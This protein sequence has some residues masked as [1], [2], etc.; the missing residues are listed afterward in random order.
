ML[1]RTNRLGQISGKASAAAVLAFALA[2]TTGSQPLAAEKAAVPGYVKQATWTQTMLATR[3][4]CRK[5]LADDAQNSKSSAFKPFISDAIRGEGPGQKVSVNVAG[6]DKLRLVTVLEQMPGNC[7]I[8]GEARLIAKDGTET[9]LSKLKPL[10]VRVGWGQLLADKNWQDHSLQIGE[11]QFK[12]GLWVH[13]DSDLCYSLGGKYERFEAWVG[14]DKDRAGGAARF[15]VLAAASD[16]VPSAW[17]QLAKDFP[18]ESKW[19]L[20]DSGRGKHLDWFYNSGNVRT[21]QGLIQRVAG[22][23]GS[24]GEQVRRDL[25]DLQNAKAAPDDARWLELYARACKCREIAPSLQKIWLADLR[26]GLEKSLADLLQAKAAIDDPRWQ[27]IA[28]QSASLA[29]AVGSAQPVNLA[30][31]RASIENLASAMPQQFESKDKLLERLT[32]AETKWSGLLPAVL[33]GNE[34]AIKQLPSLC[35][36]VQS[37][38]GELLLSIRGLRESVSRWSASRP[39]EEWQSQY[40]SLQ[41]DLGNPAH[42]Q[43]VAGETFRKESLIL[44]TD[45]DP[46]DVVLRRTAALLADLKR[47][48]ASGLEP[49]ETQLASLNEASGKIKPENADARYALFAAA[50][51]LRREIAFKNPLLDCDQIVFIKRHRA[52]FNHMCDQYYAMAARPGGGLYVL[53]NSFGTEPKVR[54]VLADCVVENGRLKGQKLN[55]GPSATPDFRFDGMG[56]L[57][58][59]DHEGGSFLSPDLSYDGRTIA[60]AYVECRGDKLHRHHTDPAQGHWHEGRCYHVFTVQADG[61]SLRQLTDGTWN[62]FD[63]CW[64]PNGRIAFISERRGGYLRC[65]RVCPT[66][67]LYDM[68]ADGGDIACMSFHETNEWHPSVTH[69]GRILY[70]RWDYVDRFGCTAHHPWIT[71]LDGR[72]S[73][74]VHGNFAAR[75]ARPDMELDCRAIPGSQKFIATA[76][77][78]HGQAYGSLVAIDPRVEDDDAMAPIRRITPEVG[79]PE[80]QGGAQV[81]GTPWP[82]SEDY[83]LCVYDAGM[84]HGSGR[85]G[86][87]YER[88]DYGIYLVDSFGNKELLYRDPEIACL[89]PI[90]LKARPKPITPAEFVKRGPATDPAQRPA[91]APPASQPQAT[92]AVVNVYDSLAGW[93]EGTKVKS[94][95]VL[96]VLP[97]SVPSGAPPHETGLRVAL[98]ADSVVPVRYVL[99]T[100]PV[101]PDGSAHFTVPANK[102]MFFQALDDRGL[103]VQSMRSATY[104]H[105]G[106]RLVCAGCHEPKH[107]VTQPSETLPLAMK[108]APSALAPDVEGSNPFSYPL[109]VQPVLDRHCAG[110]H[111][112]KKAINLGREPIERKWYASYNS[113]VQKY[114]FHDYGNNLRTY[115]GQFGARGSKLFDLLE[116]GHYDVKL[117]EEDFHRLMLWLDCTSMFYGVYEKEGGEAQLRGEVALPTLE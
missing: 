16:P 64:L 10:Y 31:L 43:K 50:C 33:G 39:L 104:L 67:T 105:E 1:R 53:S 114:G 117:P 84:Q 108:R 99:G 74:A 88:G 72:D 96:Q 58:G 110:C 109:L 19:L 59:P 77:P 25:R 29:A 71:T 63:P 97:M 90:P 36:D 38:R 66:Y 18:V 94:L 86:A 52:L 21:E 101:E 11:R 49:L 51:S 24:I 83:Y 26:A 46:A 92:V 75:D 80:S 93:P 22:Q 44:E 14:L 113:L 106:E 112:E 57:I 116:K 23:A 6:L 79:F 42:F 28:S 35:S 45:R 56:N 69:D 89:S 100:V 81:Y 5:I 85:Q 82:L 40:A 47:S 98:A 34:A 60:F 70:T 54:D 102:E 3:E 13:A 78:H 103:A 30:S 32:A 8:W 87:E 111:E 65:G 27:Q 37:L 55:G 7:H 107:R 115:P 4:S 12:H 95:R 68:A 15:K 73:R 91:I 41:Y 62:D 2:A 48:K 20:D 17:Q 61:S 76:A 9:P